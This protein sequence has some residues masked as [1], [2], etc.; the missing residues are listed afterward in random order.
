MR[1]ALA[2]TC[3]LE[4]SN[5]IAFN[6]LRY[7]ANKKQ[8]QFLDVCACQS[9]KICSCDP[10]RVCISQGGMAYAFLQPDGCVLCALSRSQMAHGRIR[11][12]A[13]AVVRRAYMS[14]EL[15]YLAEAVLGMDRHVGRCHAPRAVPSHILT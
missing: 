9:N 10:Y 5:Y 15:S 1:Y 3:A 6:R 2:V 14:L 8:R 13:M 12:Q 4:T 11:K 7:S